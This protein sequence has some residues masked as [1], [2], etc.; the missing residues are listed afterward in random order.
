MSKK[1]R[2]DEEFIKK[3]VDETYRQVKTDL[4]KQYLRTRDLRTMLNVS[5]GTLQ[6]MRVNGDIP[7]TKLAS[8][9]I[10]YPYNG[11]IEALEALTVWRKE[12]ES[13]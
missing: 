12:G 4:P 10:L 6:Q 1:R 7:Y 5:E 8:G 9:T 13:W 3:V 2:K 11:V